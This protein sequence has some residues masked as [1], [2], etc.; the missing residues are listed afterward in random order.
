[1]QS[2]GSSNNYRIINLGGTSLYI[3]GVKSVVSFGESEMQFQLNKQLIVVT[4]RELKVKYFL[5]SHK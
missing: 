1:M 2:V 3:E 5:L 4:G